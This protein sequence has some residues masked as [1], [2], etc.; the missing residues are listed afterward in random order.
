[1]EVNGRIS[2]VLPIRSGTSERGAWQ[3]QDFFL[4]YFWWQNQRDATKVLLSLT[5]SDRI[6][7]ADLHEGD[8]VTV[9]YYIEAHEYNG[10]FYNNVR[11]LGVDNHSKKAQVEEPPAAPIEAQGTPGIQ[12]EGEPDDLPY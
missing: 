2:K 12:G 7:E 9:R 10:R 8:E 4:E 5:G 6:R 1:M 11:C 3:S